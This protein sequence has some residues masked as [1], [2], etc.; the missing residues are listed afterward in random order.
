MLLRRLLAAGIIVHVTEENRTIKSLDD[1]MT[2]IQNVI[3]SFADQEFSKKLSERIG[4]VWQSKKDAAIASGTPIGNSLPV[5]LT[6]EGQVK[7]RDRIVDP[8]KIVVV[9]EQTPK[10]I[11]AATVKKM[12]TLAAQGCWFQE[13]TPAIKRQRAFP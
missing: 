9:T 2:V 10:K 6:I 5:W 4:R 8:G 7:V 1:L 11:P 13:H 12:F 3:R